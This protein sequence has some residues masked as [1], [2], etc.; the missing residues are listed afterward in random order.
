MNPGGE[1]VM[2]GSDILMVLGKPE[3]I[4]NAFPS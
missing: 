2:Q 3:D 1:E 4:L